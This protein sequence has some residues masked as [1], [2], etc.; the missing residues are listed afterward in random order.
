MYLAVSCSKTSEDKTFHNHDKVLKLKNVCTLHWKGGC[1]SMIN[2]NK[3]ICCSGVNQY[4][5]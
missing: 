5:C 4:V 1:S 3:Y 2:M